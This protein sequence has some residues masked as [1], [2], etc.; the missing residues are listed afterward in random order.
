MCLGRTGTVPTAQYFLPEYMSNNTPLQRKI[1]A[2][3]NY[4]GY[5]PMPPGPVLEPMRPNF[6]NI[7]GPWNERIL[8]LLK[9]YASTANYTANGEW[10]HDEDLDEF[11]SVFFARLSTIR[12]DIRA[13]EPIGQESIAQAFARF[14]RDTV[15]VRKVRSRVTSRRE[16][17]CCRPSPSVHL[18]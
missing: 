7:K 18:S 15:G 10:E 13:M 16:T 8:N 12:C 4:P 1:E 17:V 14:Q 3:E 11:E 6:K 2:Y 5:G 9:E